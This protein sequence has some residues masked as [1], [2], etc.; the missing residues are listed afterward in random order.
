MRGS[1]QA[2]LSCITRSRIIPAH[3]GLTSGLSY[4]CCYT[5]DHPRACGAHEVVPC[6]AVGRT[7]SSPRMRGSPDLEGI[8][9]EG[10]G[11]IPAYAGLTCQDETDCLR[12]EDH[13]RVCG[14]HFVSFRYSSRVP[15]SSPR[16]RGSLNN[17]KQSS[18]A[19]GIIP[20]YAGLTGRG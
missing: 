18:A 3:A 16:M 20:A 5:W 1:H 11:I 10:L 17:N 14:A 2:P 13:P 4:D 6:R 8:K 9:N 7:G 15:G 12:D 19:A